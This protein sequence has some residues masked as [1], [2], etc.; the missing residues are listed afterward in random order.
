MVWSSVAV[1]CNQK[2]P[3]HRD[4]HN[5]G[6][7]SN[8]L[9]GLGNYT[10]GELWVETQDDRPGAKEV[11]QTTEDGRK[12]NG[13]V[14][15]TRHEV[16]QFDPKCWHGTCAY[17]GNRYALT[18]YVCRGHQQA[19]QAERV[20]LQVCGFPLP[21]EEE[22]EKEGNIVAQADDDAQAY[23]AAGPRGSFQSKLSDE[24]IKRQL[25]LLHAAT[26]HGSTR[27]LV[28]ALKRRGASDRVIKMA[29]EF[30]C[31]VCDEKK[32]IGSRHVATLEP[33]PPK[34]STVSADVGH[35][36][37]P[38]TGEHVQFMLIIDEASRF[39]IA[40]VLTRG[41]KQSPNAATC[42]QYFQEAWCEYFGYPRVLRLD[43][44]GAFRSQTVENYCDRHSIHVDLIPGEAHHQI[45]V[46]EQAVKGVKEVMTKLC[47]HTPDLTAEEALANSLSAF[48]SREVIRGFSP[49]QHLMGQNPDVTGRFT[50]N[51][52][53]GKPELFIENPSG[54]I[55]RA[56]QLRAEAEKAHADWNAAQRIKRAMNSRAKPVF[57]FVPGELV[58]YWRSQDSEKGRRQPGGKHG[59]FQGPARILA[60][61]TRRDKHGKL[62]PGSAV[63]CVRGRNLLK[64]APEQLRRA[65][66]R[67]ELLESLAEGQRATPWTFTKVAE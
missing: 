34:L 65:S 67:E 35:W 54:E 45:G 43:P 24:R 30:R 44:A 32:K 31:S 48:N 33:L 17:Q 8:W 36:R 1:S 40:R 61:E 29:E 7:Y 57:D 13:V 62:R 49:M 16:V 12:L 11:V 60:T 37:H 55:H 42:L 22:R 51:D 53:P 14:H 28:E 41:L 15:A 2:A 50:A 25:Y 21:E 4:I 46:C 38:T 23:A 3:I 59:R 9:H 39:R 63:W 5:D 47:E 19:T 64:C 52:S 18:V 20:E 58:Y 66:E 6:R 26:G 10:G 27:H 56:A